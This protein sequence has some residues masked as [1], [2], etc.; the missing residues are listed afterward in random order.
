MS[1][2]EKPMLHE[3]LSATIFEAC[4]EVM[5]ELG[6]GFL[7]SVYE[8]ALVIALQGKG[9]TARAQVPICVK[10]RGKNVGNFIADLFVEDRVVVELK[11]VKALLPEHSA[12][13]INYLKASGIDVGLLV[14]FR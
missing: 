3:R 6:A 13:T 10:F 5:N 12:Q 7:E 11:T 14:K 4:F 9:L 1:M 8:R 2:F